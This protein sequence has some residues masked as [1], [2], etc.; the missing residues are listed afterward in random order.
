MVNMK[1]IHPTRRQQRNRLA[2]LELLN[3]S[4]GPVSSARIA[5]SLG[6]SGY[7][8][9]ERTVRAYLK[10]MDDEGLTECIGRSGRIITQTGRSE[11][12]SRILE[13]IGFVSARIDRLTFQM[14]FDLIRRSGTV[15][16]NLTTV[17]P[18]IL[19]ECL[20]DIVSV[21]EKGY[22]MGTQL[23]L[24]GPG[25]SLGET[26]VPPDH[27]GLCTVCSVTLNGVLLKHGVPVRS[28]Y[29]GLLELRDGSAMRFAELTSYEGTS[30]DP[31]A[32]FIR[33]GMTNYLGAI[34]DGTGLIG[35]GFRE[36][37]AESRELVAGLAAKLDTVGMGAFMSIGC[38]GQMLLNLPVREGCCGMVLIGG[39]NPV[40]I[41]V[42]RGHRIHPVALAGLIE[43]HRLHHFSELPAKLRAMGV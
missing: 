30:L 28:P 12:A 32:M 37:P 42:E 26:T 41:M 17:K 29:S 4:S 14:G 5:Q 7:D 20:D 9:S 27:V 18:Y 24:L 31:L 2:I 3:V 6:D 15:V 8:V 33:G 22:A 38:P 13:R 10:Q 11:V 1:R 39:L 16:A 34:H 43:Y 19:R 25:D 36:I 35:A 23:A 40:S 21:F